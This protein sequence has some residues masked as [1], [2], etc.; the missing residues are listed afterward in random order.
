ML[1]HVKV[2][3]PKFCLPVPLVQN[4]PHFSI[5]F[6]AARNSERLHTEVLTSEV[7]SGINYPREHR[8]SALLS[9]DTSDGAFSE[10]SIGRFKI[11][12]HTLTFLT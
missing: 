1:I 8:R 3:C 10:N 5:E 7:S 12:R 11:R 9:S 4:I 2:Y 6:R